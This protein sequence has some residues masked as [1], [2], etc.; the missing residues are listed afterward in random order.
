MTTPKSITS[1]R[2]GISSALILPA[3]TIRTLH[4]VDYIAQTVRIGIQVQAEEE[5]GKRAVVLR[6]S[7]LLVEKLL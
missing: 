2:P 5:V 3:N 6:L 7:C 4:L 1:Y